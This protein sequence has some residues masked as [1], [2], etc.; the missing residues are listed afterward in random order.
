MIMKDSVSRVTQQNVASLA[1][2]LLTVPK[3]K[4]KSLFK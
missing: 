2:V 3:L 1:H 4:N